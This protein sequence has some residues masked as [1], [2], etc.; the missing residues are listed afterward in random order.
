MVMQA[1]DYLPE[2]ILHDRDRESPESIVTTEFHDCDLRI[3]ILD[4]GIHAGEGPRCRI[5]ADTGINNFVV[6]T[7]TGQAFLQQGH[8][9][10]INGNF[11]TGTETV[12]QYQNT[13]CIR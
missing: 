13:A 12:A 10:M 11:I 4:M 7:F 3:H 1:G 9:A 6:V 8:P 2:V 5:T